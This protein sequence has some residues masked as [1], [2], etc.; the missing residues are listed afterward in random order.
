[1]PM[2][3]LVAAEELFQEFPLWKAHSRV[4]HEGDGTAY[5]IIEV[6][7]PDQANVEHGL[8][9]D[10]SN[11]EITVGFDAYHSHF[12]SWSEDGKQF[13]TLSAL[14]FIKQL[15]SE[16]VAILSWWRDEEWCG[17][18]QLE[19]KDGT[20]TLGWE[21]ETRGNRVRIRSWKGTLNHDAYA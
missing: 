4:E 10:T 11:E 14:E 2:S 16:R 21:T 8:V 18:T 7:P 20:V 6:D 9:I 17:S 1:M 19:V 5:M 3:P 15:V 13:G 12:D